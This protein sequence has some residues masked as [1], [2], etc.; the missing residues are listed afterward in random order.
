MN[1]LWNG[2]IKAKYDMEGVWITKQVS[3]TYGVSLWKTITRGM[4]ETM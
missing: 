3:S 1:N 2:V 4:G